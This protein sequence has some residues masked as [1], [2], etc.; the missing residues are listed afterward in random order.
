MNIKWQKLETRPS[1]SRLAQG[2]LETIYELMADF[3]FPDIHAKIKTSQLFEQVRFDSNVLVW[4]SP[5]NVTCGQ[6]SP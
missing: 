4:A 1:P 5:H 3:D 6:L 2:S